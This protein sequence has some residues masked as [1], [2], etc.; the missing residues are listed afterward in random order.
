MIAFFMIFLVYFVVFGSRGFVAFWFLKKT[1][2]E[3]KKHFN[4]LCCVCIICRLMCFMT[5]GLLCDSFRAV[6]FC[7]LRFLFLKFC[8]SF[9]FSCSFYYIFFMFLK[10]FKFLM[11]FAACNF[12]DFF[13]QN[14]CDCLQSQR[15]WWC[16]FVVAKMTVTI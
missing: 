8:I 12:S 16:L 9:V 2:N 15:W 3:N 4:N 7:L 6:F 10:A 11:K 14:F 5:S 13:F 1:S